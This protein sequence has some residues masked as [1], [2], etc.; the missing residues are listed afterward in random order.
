MDRLQKL[1]RDLG[2]EGKELQDFVEQENKR[3]RD[4]RA[5]EREIEKVKIASEEAKIAQQRE[6]ELV[7]VKAK[8]ARIAQQREIEL[9][10]VA[11][12]E[13]KLAKQRETEL[14]NVKAEEAKIAQQREIELA[15]VEVAKIAKENEFELATV[16]SRG[17]FTSPLTP[18]DN[19][20]KPPADPRSCPLSIIPRDTLIPPRIRRGPAMDPPPRY[21]SYSTADPRWAYNVK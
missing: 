1:G 19:F 10:K 18:A 11:A 20:S 13:A 17:F 21:L 8:E 9:E 16:Q 12:E 4:E 3:K 7:N 14:A 5:A 15:I 6:I 2:Y